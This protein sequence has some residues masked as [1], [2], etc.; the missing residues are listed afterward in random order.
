MKPLTLVLAFLPLIVSSLLSRFLPHGDIGV[1]GLAAAVIALIVIGTTGR[2]GR[3][4]SSVAA[5]WRCSP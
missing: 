1:A 3:R 4:R 2:P 5:R